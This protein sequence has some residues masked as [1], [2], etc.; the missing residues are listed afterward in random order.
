MKSTDLVQQLSRWI[1]KSNC[2]GGPAGGLHCFRVQKS[3]GLPGGSRLAAVSVRHEVPRGGGAPEVVV[4][5]LWNLRRG[6]V[7]P[8]H[9]SETCLHLSSYRAW[10]AQV[11]EKAET[12]GLK[13]RHRLTVHA[14]V[15][16]TEVRPSAAADLLSHHGREVAFWTYRLRDGRVEFDPYYGEG[17]PA[18]KSVLE[19]MLDHLAWRALAASEIQAFTS[20]DVL[21][22][23][24]ILPTTR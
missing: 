19:P 13:R 14:N 10:Y 16:G 3:A 7:E 21:S 1:E 24:P 17:R 5:E 22:N 18:P 23:M 8:S 4:V 12:R 20:D 6:P 11:L 15:V 9:V 2:T